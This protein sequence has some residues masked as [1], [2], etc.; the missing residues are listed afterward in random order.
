MRESNRT[1]FWIAALISLGWLGY[2]FLV[3]GH[4]LLAADTTASAD[5]LPRP[6]VIA[7]ALAP[8]AAIFAVA[9]AFGPQ[10][11]PPLLDAP[12]S[13]EETESRLAGVTARIQSLRESL[14]QELSALDLA[15]TTLEARS[16]AARLLMDDLHQ[17][18][19]AAS[20]AHQSL[21]A[22]IPEANRTADALTSA[23]ADT[24]NRAAIESDRLQSSMR[25]LA[26]ELGVLDR[27]SKATAES[28]AEARQ[29]TNAGM[30]A[31]RSEADSLFEVLENTLVAKRQTI[32]QESEQ[33]I[34]GLSDNYSRFQALAGQSLGALAAQ[35]SQL[36]QT[37]QAIS[38]RLQQSIADTARLQEQGTQFLQ[39]MDGG[40]NES[41]S[42]AHSL[43][44]DLSAQSEQM[45][46]KFAR[47]SDPFDRAQQMVAD[48]TGGIKTLMASATD[49][50]D[51][52]AARLPQSAA[53]ATDAT[54]QLMD[55][56]KSLNEHVEDIAGSLEN[57]LQPLEQKQTDIQTAAADY[58]QQKQAIE[59]AG[60]ALVVEL[61][62]A[63]LLLDEVEDLTRDT[64]LAAASGLVD[65]FTQVRDIAN[66]ATGSMRQTLDGLIDE[67]RISLQQAADD[68]LRRSFAEPIA[69]YVQQAQA[70][71]A[72]AAERTASSMAA[73]AEAV[74]LIEDRTRS[75]H[76]WLTAADHEDLTESSAFLM[77]ELSQ[78]AVS[79][80]DALD[81]PMND[82]DWKA[83][84]KGERGLFSQ[85]AHGLLRRRDASDIA[86]LLRENN[87]LAQ[88]ARTYCAS[89]EA[90][91]KR[92][93]ESVPALGAALRGSEQGRLAALLSEV[94][95][96]HQV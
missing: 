86:A 28:M 23:F 42:T 40:L 33:I 34:T 63:K 7:L 48:L 6:L 88:S 20:T 19:K 54:T 82:A 70:S 62:Q 15:T 14:G 16:E 78:A 80:A 94:M 45:E 39:Q 51:L 85:R 91:A 17:G 52:L 53:S 10:T 22:I 64:S 5:I 76:A 92:F 27:Q 87:R 38:A 44:Q 41:R 25:G 46:Q 68:A 57:L 4:D 29:Q 59:D 73:L 9:A 84:Q 36:G 81:H 83:W 55:Q 18:S 65:T 1:A 89:F 79:I 74:R 37:T 21:Q 77:D 50:S 11:R 26:N 13:L 49:M 8:I 61:Q 75:S 35:I 12:D 69:Q 24:A 56:V 60:S 2:C 96:Q 3:P 71:A 58:A 31:I 72:G 32:L 43:M 47:L 93:E 90:L 66:Q 30:R 95:D 67:A